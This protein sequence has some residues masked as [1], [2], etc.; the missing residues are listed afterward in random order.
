MFF[1]FGG[2]GGVRV[3]KETVPT[4][5]LFSSRISFYPWRMSCLASDV[6]FPLPFW[7]LISL[8]TCGTA[9]SPLFSGAPA[10]A[11]ATF[12]HPDSLSALLLPSYLSAL[13][14]LRC[15]SSPITLS[16]PGGPAPLAPITPDSP[17]PYLRPPQSSHP[18]RPQLCSCATSSPH[19]TPDPL[20]VHHLP[21]LFPSPPAVGGERK[22]HFPSAGKSGGLRV[23]PRGG[24]G[25][26]AR[27]GAGSL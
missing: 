19:A 4:P 6:L 8:L 10:P 15:S 1:I 3:W 12:H 17:G 23:Q 9:R 21:Q 16:P 22:R 2:R 25:R 24:G 26:A 5:H 20:D 27:G 14:P 7:P 13:G 18:T 11:S